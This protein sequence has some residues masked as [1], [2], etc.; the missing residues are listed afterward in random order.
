MKRFLL[1]RCG[2]ASCNGFELVADILENYKYPIKIN[3]IYKQ[4][5]EKYNIS[6]KSIERRIRYYKTICGYSDIK[7]HEFIS[8]LMIE[9]S[10][11]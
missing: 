10:D 9:S 1:A 4:L 7:N 6:Y 2:N 3:D 5:G 11:K 8:M